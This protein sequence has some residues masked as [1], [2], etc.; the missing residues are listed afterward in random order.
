MTQLSVKVNLMQFRSMRSIPMFALAML[1]V[2]A[3]LPCVAQAGAI[4]QLQSFTSG[5]HAASGDFTQTL[6]KKSTSR[7]VPASTGSFSF[8]R[9]GKF[10]WIYAKPYEQTLLADG[11]KLWMYDKD[12]NQVTVRKLGTALGESPAAILFGSNDLAAK[13]TLK[14]AGARDGLD[15]LEAFP[16]GKESTFQS[17]AIGFKDGLPQAMELRDAFGQTSVL[18][19]SN[20]VRNPSFAAQQ[21][22]F[23]MPKG[24]DVFEQ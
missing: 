17:V 13:F 14:E 10:R 3:G 19:F 6:V 9:P 7:P 11:E 1:A 12:L 16:K 21:F 4:E 24:A 18:N 15:W 20:L 23:D 22:R 5:T 8:A 2:V